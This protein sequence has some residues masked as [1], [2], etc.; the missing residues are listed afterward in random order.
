MDEI[1]RFNE[2]KSQRIEAASNDSD[3]FKKSLEWM[4]VADEYKFTY[5]FAWMGIPIIKFP[6]DMIVQQE[7]M[8]RI[9]PDLIIET[10]VAHGGSVIFS[11]SIQQMLGID[12]KVVGIDIDIREHN[13]IEMNKNPLMSRV[14]LYEGDS[15]SPEILE[16]VSKHVAEAEC[17][18]VV[19]DSHHSH[20]HVLKELNLY[21][22]FVSKNSY[23]ILPDTFIEFFPKGYY[24]KDRPWDVGDNPYTAMKEFLNSNSDFEIDS[25][26]ARKALISE[27]I[28]GYLRRK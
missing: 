12:G 4:Q 22:Q 8:S 16:K 26:F 2:L 5:N 3:L 1:S 19:L 27:S 10:G 20:E 17:I 6:N 7:I 13:R 25:E 9:R 28:D 21:S 23:V 15:T 24:S 14:V 11:A 18:L